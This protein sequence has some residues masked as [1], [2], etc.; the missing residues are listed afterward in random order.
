MTPYRHERC[1]TYVQI[2]NSKELL[3]RQSQGKILSPQEKVIARKEA[4]LRRKNKKA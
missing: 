3:L 1:E 2:Y 4:E